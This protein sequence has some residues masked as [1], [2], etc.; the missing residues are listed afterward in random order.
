M[1]DYRTPLEI[2]LQQDYDDYINRSFRN[3]IR[4]ELN[5]N[6]KYINEYNTFITFNPNKPNMDLIA[7]QHRIEYWYS[8]ISCRLFRG[9]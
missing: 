2:K 4:N 5:F 3:Q 1:S 8:N 7:L 6:Y 9:R